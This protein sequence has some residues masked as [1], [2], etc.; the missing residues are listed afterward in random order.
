[1]ILPKTFYILEVKLLP[2]FLSK[3]L[4]IQLDDFRTLGYSRYRWAAP[5][6]DSG[7][8]VALRH[9][10]DQ[11]NLFALLRARSSTVTTISTSRPTSTAPSG[12]YPHHSSILHF[13]LIHA[14]ASYFFRQRC[15]LD[16]H[17]FRSTC[18][19]GNSPSFLATTTPRF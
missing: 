10:R 18:A 17:T 14:F 9:M 5:G 8:G 16:G 6:R 4:Q 3:I 15:R 2:T 13:G 7:D 11:P 12:R 19:R 1:M